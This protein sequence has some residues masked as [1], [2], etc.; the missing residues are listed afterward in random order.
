ME[1]TSRSVNYPAHKVFLKARLPHVR[2]SLMSYSC[3]DEELQR[4]DMQ[5]LLRCC[6]AITRRS[7]FELGTI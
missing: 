1:L 2:E 5:N 4:S 6:C 3:G 7:N